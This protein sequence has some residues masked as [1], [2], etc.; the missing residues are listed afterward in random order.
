[1]PSDGFTWAFSLRQK[2]E[3]CD[4]DSGNDAPDEDYASKALEDTSNQPKTSQ[5]E[6]PTVVFRENPWSIAK[7]NAA[8]RPQVPMGASPFLA[9]PAASP[10]T[11]LHDPSA[12]P[13]PQNPAMLKCSTSV[14]SSKNVPRSSAK[15]KGQSTL[16][17]ALRR[18]RNQKAAPD[19]GNTAAKIT[20]EPFSGA[21]APLKTSLPSPGNRSNTSNAKE[22]V[23]SPSVFHHSCSPES[24]ESTGMARPQKKVHIELP[25]PIRI[26]NGTSRASLAHPCMCFAYLMS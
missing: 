7:V 5:A 18:R 16:E 17:A 22:L 8:S 9:S 26:S 13:N 4:S 11:A 1:M 14:K 23:T 15:I 3:D 2:G 6:E 12:S 24:I 21:H 10:S 19:A 20:S 25:E